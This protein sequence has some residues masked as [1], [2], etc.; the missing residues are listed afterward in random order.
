MNIRKHTNALLL[1]LVSFSTQIGFSH[2]NQ[3]KDTLYY[4]SNWKESTKDNYEYYR[5]LPLKTT[6]S[7]SLIVDYYK[8]G[9]MQMQ[10]YAYTDSLN[11][12]VGDVYWYLENR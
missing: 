1:L 3:D 6:G 5:A 12:F 7:L 11:I 8:N 4:D 10:G 9:K 2:T